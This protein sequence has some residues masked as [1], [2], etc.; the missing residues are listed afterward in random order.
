MKKITSVSKRAVA[1]FMAVLMLCSFTAVTSFADISISLEAGGTVDGVTLTASPSENMTYTVKNSPTGSNSTVSGSVIT[2]KEVKPG[3]YTFEAVGTDEES[4]TI[5]ITVQEVTLKADKNDEERTLTMSCDDVSG[6]TYKVKNTSSYAVNG[7]LIFNLKS[8]T[9][10]RVYGF[11]YDSAAK[12]LYYGEILSEKIK[13]T[14]NPPANVKPVATADSITVESISGAEYQLKIDG[15]EIIRD[16]QDSNVFTGLAV[17]TWYTVSARLKAT[18]TKLASE[19]TSVS[20]KTLQNCKDTPKPVN[21]TEVTKT[22]LTVEALAGYEYSKDGSTWSTNNKFTG[23]TAGKD[24]TIYQR[25]AATEEYAPSAP[26]SKSIT[27]NTAEVYNAS[28]TKLSAVSWDDAENVRV[29]KENKFIL[30]GDIRTDGNIQWGDTRIIPYSFSD[31]NT[32]IYKAQMTAN[33]KGSQFTGKY[34][35]TSTG[36]KSI[37]VIYIKEEYK[38]TDGWVQVGEPIVQNSKVTA[39]HSD[40]GAWGFLVQILRFLTTTLPS[41]LQTGMKWL[42]EHGMSFLLFI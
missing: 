39:L 31:G 33:A 26:V 1:V 28:A 7:N 25:I 11:K 12:K 24:Y 22:T 29:G 21:F 41:Y 34:N 35:P 4:A 19:P 14:Q 27:T 20:I 17:G 6:L 10:Y 15:G 36:E 32:T 9:A 5:T 16:W 18:D 30:N 2:L 13:D 38:G 40:E 42:Q 3:S 23:L 8:G 37:T